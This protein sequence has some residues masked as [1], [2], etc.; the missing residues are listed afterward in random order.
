[1]KLDSHDYL[2][3][4]QDA[5]CR[6]P[7]DFDFARGE[8]RD[9]QGHVFRT[10]ANVS[11]SIEKGPIEYTSVLNLYSYRELIG[12]MWRVPLGLTYRIFGW[13]TPKAF[14]VTTTRHISSMDKATVYG[15]IDV[16]YDPFRAEPPPLEELLV[17]YDEALSTRPTAGLMDPVRQMRFVSSALGL[18]K[19]VIPVPRDGDHGFFVD[20]MAPDSQLLAR[21]GEVLT[22]ANKP[23]L[24]VRQ[25]PTKGYFVNARDKV[26]GTYNVVSVERTLTKKEE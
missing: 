20:I 4:V 14:G 5:F 9:E 15:G 17:A 23:R 16:F 2:G 13:R 18:R 10:E 12:R 8:V 19:L 6:T 25:S 21:A 24:V 11:H 3:A 1:M 22:H 26:V 7:S